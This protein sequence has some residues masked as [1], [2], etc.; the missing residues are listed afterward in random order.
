MVW[1]H[2]YQYT[3]SF[4]VEGLKYVACG[5]TYILQSTPASNVL[6]RRGG[7][8]AYLSFDV[9]NQDGIHVVPG[10]PHLGG[11]VSPG[12]VR[13]VFGIRPDADGLYNHRSLEGVMSYLG[14]SYDR[15]IVG[16]SLRERG[17]NQRYCGLDW[18]YQTEEQRLRDDTEWYHSVILD[19]VSPLLWYLGTV[20]KHSAE[21][22]HGWEDFQVG[23]VYTDDEVSEDDPD[24]Q[25]SQQ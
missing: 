14:Q 7:G 24:D 1:E 10:N 2:R 19:Q 6:S 5:K 23:R 22:Y 4:F 11:A 20:V 25:V 8:A 3:S 15:F 9:W 12:T 21:V 13:E 18:Y 17:I 16:Y